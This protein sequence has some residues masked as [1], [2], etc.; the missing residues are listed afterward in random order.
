MHFV[1]YLKNDFLDSRFDK[2]KRAGG[3]RETISENLA[4]EFN[5]PAAD[6]AETKTEDNLTD[7]GVNPEMVKRLVYNPIGILPYFPPNK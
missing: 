7:L 5:I 4:A 2:L 1:Y 6:S 3:I